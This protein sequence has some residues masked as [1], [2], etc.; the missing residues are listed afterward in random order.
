M[1]GHDLPPPV[2][3]TSAGWQ[4][5]GGLG[6]IAATAGCV[7]LLSHPEWVGW[8]LLSSCIVVFGVYLFLMARETPAVRGRL[9]AHLF[10]VVAAVAFW[11][12]YQ[13]FASSILV[14]T[15][16]HVQRYISSWQVPSSIFNSLN[17]AF[18][19]F[20][21][22]IFILLWRRLAAA[23]KEP[24]DFIKLGLGNVL[25]GLAFLVLVAGIAMTPVGSKTPLMWIIGFQF[26]LALGEMLVGPVGMSLTKAHA[27]RRLAGFAMGV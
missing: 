12:I 19:L 16:N 2:A 3:S 22:P 13:E 5:L 21:S 18:V 14:F 17:P 10:V 24:N 7:F 20:L 15:Q 9:L 1:D 23:R 25:A 4:L 26:V 6:V 11:A 27:P 8:F